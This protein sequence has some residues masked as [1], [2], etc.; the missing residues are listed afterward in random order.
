MDG[1]PATADDGIA[2]YRAG[3]FDEA[4]GVLREV[5]GQRP[6]D[7]R[8][9]YH[10]GLAYS[11]AGLYAAAADAFAKAIA[12]DEADAYAHNRLAFALTQVG[13]IREAYDHIR[14]ALTLNPRYPW[15]FYNLGLLYATLGL[16]A[17]AAAAFARF[18][19]LESTVTGGKPR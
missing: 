2:L 1:R 16:C 17:E 13:K 18:T 14:Q 6:D 8:V 3:R 9:H 12:L 15:P 19:A 11:A 5:A 10:L 4:V 7:G